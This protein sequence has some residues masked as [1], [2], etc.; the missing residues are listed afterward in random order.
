MGIFHT[1]LVVFIVSYAIQLIVITLAYG[2]TSFWEVNDNVV[3]KKSIEKASVIIAARNELENL[4]KLLNSLSKQKGVSFEVIV[5]LDRCEDES[6]KYLEEFTQKDARFKY[7]V[8]K[9][10]PKEIISGKKWAITKAIETA[11]SDILILT[12]AD[13]WP[14]SDFWLKAIV[15]KYSDPNIQIV[16]GYGGYEKRSTWIN[17]VIQYDTLITGGLYLSMA[18]LGM[19]FMGVGRNI[20]YRKSFFNRVGGFK[21]HYSIISGDDDLFVN[22]NATK[23][24]TSIIFDKNSQTYSRPKKTFSSWYHQKIRHLSVGKYY[25]LKDKLILSLVNGSQI[26]FYSSFFILLTF[27]KGTAYLTALYAIRQMLLFMT[28]SKLQENIGEKTDLKL[29][30][31]LDLFHTLYLTIVGFIATLTKKVRW[32]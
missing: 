14:A 2:N 11:E 24:N 15:E 13:C 18:N 20:S 6:Q 32:K 10:I 3:A 21:N 7:L 23:S 8:I 5:A 1:V 25:K 16:L 9:E 27:S 22:A 17:K 4:K 19:P 26:L 29:T 30:F 31:A 28:L 12:D